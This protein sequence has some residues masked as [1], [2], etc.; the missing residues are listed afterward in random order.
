MKEETKACEIQKNIIDVLQQA[1]NSDICKN[2]NLKNYITIDN[3]VDF[4]QLK[5]EVERED[6]NQVLH[7]YFYKKYNL[8]IFEF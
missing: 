5:M 7:L 8:F 1:I 2:S 6:I 3:I 4:T